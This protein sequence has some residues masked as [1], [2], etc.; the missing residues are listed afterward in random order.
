M[1]YTDLTELS[2]DQEITNLC[3]G[4]NEE[5]VGLAYKI[6]VHHFFLVAFSFQFVSGTFTLKLSTNGYQVRTK[7]QKKNAQDFSLLKSVC[8][9]TLLKH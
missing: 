8:L 5:T 1:N 9:L 7:C 4:K 2:K 6:L 3:W